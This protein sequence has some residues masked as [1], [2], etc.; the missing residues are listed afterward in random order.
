METDLDAMVGKQIKMMGEVST[1]ANQNHAAYICT[2]VCTR[3]QMCVYK[4]CF[5][6]LS[7]K[8]TKPKLSSKSLYNFK[9]LLVKGEKD[10]LGARD[11]VDYATR[12]RTVLG[13][14]LPF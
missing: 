13:S 3:V 6:H 14:M 8:S 12:S 9:I 10:S 1:Q 7:V 2:N 5:H 11:T 4:V